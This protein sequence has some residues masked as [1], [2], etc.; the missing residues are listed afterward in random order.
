MAK[1]L[2]G[3]CSWTDKELI[4]SGAFYPKNARSAEERLRYYA[5]QFPIVEVD[6]TL[7]D[8]LAGLLGASLYAWLVGLLKPG[9]S[10]WRQ[11]QNQQQEDNRQGQGHDR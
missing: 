9:N 11:D 6:D 5:T 7:N 3:A 1:I 8:L 4:D 2:V 10:E